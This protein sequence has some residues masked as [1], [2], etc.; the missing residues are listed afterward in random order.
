MHINSGELRAYLDGELPEQDH[1]RLE[2]HLE[3][4]Q[5]CQH[6]LAEINTRARSTASLL[7]TLPGA[8]SSYRKSTPALAVFNR[9][10]AE[11]EKQSMFTKMKLFRGRIAAAVVLV[12]I[13][14]AAFA[15]PQVRVIANNFLGIFRVEQVTVLPL[16][17]SRLDAEWGSSGVQ[18]DQLLA[19]D[20]DIEMSGDTQTAASI[21]EAASMAGFR[22][23]LPDSLPS[24]DKLEV[25][26]P[27][28]ASYTI[29]L[30]KVRKLLEAIGQDPQL[31]PDHVDGQEVS[32]QLYSSVRAYYGSCEG[33]DYDPD[34]PYLGLAEDCLVV[35]Q[36]PSP[37]MNTPQ[38]LDLDRIA[39]AFLAAAGMPEA[40]A[41]AFSQRIDWATTLVIPIPPQ[42]KSIDVQVDGVQGVLIQPNYRK[43]GPFIMIW[44]KDGI[45][46]ALNG[47][48]YSNSV[49]ETAN[50]MQ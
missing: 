7:G 43:D 14:A 4:C 36:M 17:L 29:D 49:L 8:A 18:L 24:P 1:L 13:L 38:G 28:R 50:S 34:E 35:L 44:V 2:A 9:F 33:A 3:H 20:M 22:L 15:F 42:S 12:A 46:Y 39:A 32:A 48:G 11:K 16:D 21:E 37:V 40:E 27:A 6:S 45:L 25:D 26:P 19:S 31:L 41:Q 47:I 10:I 5:Y 30:A 23:R